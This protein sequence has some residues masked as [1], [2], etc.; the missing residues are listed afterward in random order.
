MKQ[1]AGTHDTHDRGLTKL[2][3][4]G[5]RNPRHSRVGGHS[6]EFSRAEET[7]QPR[8]NGELRRPWQVVL[9][10]VASSL[11][12]ATTAGAL[13]PPPQ[14]IHGVA[15]GY[16]GSPLRAKQTGQDKVRAGQI[17]WRPGGLTMAVASWL[18]K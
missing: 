11:G 14:K 13:L 1:E 4:S 6:G 3:P 18:V 9:V 15:R 12:P 7:G 2:P 16:P 5:R 17:R 8:Q 10:A